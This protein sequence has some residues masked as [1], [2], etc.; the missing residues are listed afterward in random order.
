MPTENRPTPI[1]LASNRAR[2]AAMVA[3]TTGLHVLTAGLVVDLVDVVTTAILGLTGLDSV[4]IR[5]TAATIW[6]E[7]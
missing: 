6:G 3:D 2:A 5:R 7:R 1:T 4:E